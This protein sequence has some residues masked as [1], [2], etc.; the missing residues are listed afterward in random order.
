MI[1]LGHEE[2]SIQ[3]KKGT[4]LF[5]TKTLRVIDY[6]GQ[7]QFQ[8]IAPLFVRH[9]SAGLFVIRLIDDFD[10]YPLD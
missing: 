1:L 5:G 4:E 9:A 3:P 2:D 10:P 6:G 8:D 7:P